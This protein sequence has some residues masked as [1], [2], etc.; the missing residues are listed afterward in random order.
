MRNGYKF[1]RR[2]WMISKSKVDNH[3]KQKGEI[4]PE[5]RTMTIWAERILTI[6]PEIK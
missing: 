5:V 1:G 2:P 4:F 3:I 6:A